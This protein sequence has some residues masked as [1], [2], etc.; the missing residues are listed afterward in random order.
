MNPLQA[1]QR[2]GDFTVYRQAHGGD[3]VTPGF[4]FPLAAEADGNHRHGG[5]FRQLALGLQVFAQGA[6]D[7]RHH[8][9]VDRH[10]ARAG[11]DR[12]HLV[13]LEK[14]RLHHPV[15][16]NGAIETGTAPGVGRLQS[17]LPETLPQPRGNRQDIP[18]CL[19]PPGGRAQSVDIRSPEQAHRARPGARPVGRGGLHPCRPRL[20]VVQGVYR[21]H[22]RGTIHRGMVHLE[23]N[24]ET[25]G[26]QGID[27]VQALYYIGLPQ[28]PRAIEHPRLQARHLDT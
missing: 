19:Q 28:R 10:I 3:Q 24:G 25:A 7:H 6:G 13:Q 12:P 23:K 16:R 14:P 20:Q 17:M 11:L 2:I 21:R 9:V 8:H 4:P 1:F 26:G 15:R 22:R 5:E 18:H 27:I